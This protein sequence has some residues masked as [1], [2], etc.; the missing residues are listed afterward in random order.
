MLQ[1]VFFLFTNGGFFLIYPIILAELVVLIGAIVIDLVFGDTKGYVNPSVL[2]ADLGAG[3]GKW[4]KKAR[5]RVLAGFFFTMAIIILFTFPAYVLLRL[6]SSIN[7]LYFIAS[8]IIL[9]TTFS[10][11]SIRE[12]VNPIIDSLQKN[13]IEN[14]RKHLSSIVSF[15]TA[16]MDAKN[17]S[18]ATIESIS[19][20]FLDYFLTPM[21]FFAIFG[22][23][24]AL[25]ARIM[26]SLDSAIGHRNKEYFEFGR[27][28]AI[29]KTIISY[30]PA[31]VSAGIIMFSS[32]L[33]NYR[34]QSVPLREVR[35]LTESVN[36]GWPL[37]S[38]ATCLNIRLENYG[39][40]VLNEGG[41]EPSVGDIKRTMNIYYA[42]IYISLLIFILPIMMIVYLFA[43]Y[44]VIV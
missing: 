17:I 34:V 16:D 21:M 33:L 27:W 7:F 12:R 10:I 4:F 36:V 11:T 41:F 26:V 1:A 14:A 19:R 39:Q 42:S 24:G 35:V 13:D 38:V 23:I 30:I 2:A 20:G 43:E 29:F 31:R 18:S 44:L 6:I 28:A 40:Y 3:H 22:V 8:I 5:N 32:E 37:G 15:N 25:T 9:K